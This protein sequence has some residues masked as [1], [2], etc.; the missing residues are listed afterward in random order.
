MMYPLS[1]MQGGYGIFLL[2][3]GLF[4]LF[5]AIGVLFLVV[6]AIK[7]LPG[8]KLKEVGLWMLAVGIVGAFLL[9]ALSI[10]ARMELGGSG[11]MKQ[12]GMMWE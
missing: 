1:L 12:A 9:T 2:L 8:Q 3:R 6:W 7:H 10:S 11:M 5:T 4:N